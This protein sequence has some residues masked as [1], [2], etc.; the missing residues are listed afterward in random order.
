MPRKVT[1]RSR[2]NVIKPPATAP[3][4]FYLMENSREVDRLELKTNPVAAEEQLRWAGL[5]MNMRSLE[6]GCGSGAVTRVMAQLAAPGRVMGI[7]QD[8]G[9]LAAARRRA[10]EEGS[11]IEFVRGA[12]YALPIDAAQFDFS[13]SRFLFQYLPDP[14]RALRELVRVTRPGGIVTVADLDGQ[15]EQFYPLAPKLQAD[16]DEALAV[17]GKTGFD[18][19]VGRKLYSMFFSAGLS[20]LAVRVTPYQVYAGR[21]TKEELANWDIKLDTTATLLISQTGQ[22]ARWGRLRDQLIKRLREPDLFY[23]CTLIQVRGSVKG[24]AIQAPS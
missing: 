23:F 21:L 15:I 5:K 16:L 13:W 22:K 3:A 18:T 19:R 24:C 9:R 8:E 17:L 10:A 2:T 1:S 7:D 11:A 6:V 12:A 14:A 20:D 4:A